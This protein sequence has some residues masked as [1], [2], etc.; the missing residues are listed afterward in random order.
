[1][2]GTKRL[3]LIFSV[4]CFVLSG[5][6]FASALAGTPESQPAGG[7]QSY[8]L[9]SDGDSIC[10]YSDPACTNLIGHLDVRASDLPATDREML[11]CGLLIES[12][13]QLLSLIEDYTG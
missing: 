1:M 8:I 7:E 11:E 3:F 6:A 10:V 13:Q 9:R 4:I 12:E 5:A 2:N